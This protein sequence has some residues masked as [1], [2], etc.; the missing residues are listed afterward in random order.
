MILGIP[1]RNACSSNGNISKDKLQVCADV[2]NVVFNVIE[3]LH[4]NIFTYKPMSC[5]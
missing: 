4:C 3:G 1:R 5:L 2:A